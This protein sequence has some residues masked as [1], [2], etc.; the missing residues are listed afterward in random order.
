LHSSI[1]LYKDL[2]SKTIT[3]V[4]HIQIVDDF[5]NVTV[6]RYMYCKY[7]KIDF[8]NGGFVN[9]KATTTNTTNKLNFNINNYVFQSSD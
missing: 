6:K 7:K 4:S 1:D 2:I 5:K 8:S 9:A 3:D